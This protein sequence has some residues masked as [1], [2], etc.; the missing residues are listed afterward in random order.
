MTQRA[1]V[2]FTDLRVK[3]STAY[4]SSHLIAYNSEEAMR[5]LI[6]NQLLKR[7][8]A[9]QEQLNPVHVNLHLE[10]GIKVSFKAEVI[11]DIKVPLGELTKLG[12]KAAKKKPR[13]LEIEFG[14][15]NHRYLAQAR[16]LDLNQN[17]MT[18]SRLRV[19]GLVTGKNELTHIG[20]STLEELVM[21]P[22]EEVEGLVFSNLLYAHTNNSVQIH[23]RDY[24]LDKHLIELYRDEWD[25][26]N[27]LHLSKEG[28][29][30][31]EAN[32]ARLIY[33]EK[34]NRQLQEH[35]VEFLKLEELNEFLTHNNEWIRKA[36]MKRAALLEAQ[37]DGNN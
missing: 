26:K 3:K 2:R 21:T 33:L 34:A 36:A 25:L 22:V 14:D 10:G 18:V 32:T 12:A 1:E 20:L 24:L 16:A 27:K 30:W 37:Q 8:Q 5:T 29:A 31:L 23:F 19:E 7:A 15:K 4:V 6:E 35:A 11:V 28:Q 9:L 13:P 17:N